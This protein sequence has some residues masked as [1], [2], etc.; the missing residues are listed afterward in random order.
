MVAAA[1]QHVKTQQI[2]HIICHQFAQ[3]KPQKTQKRRESRFKFIRGSPPHFDQAF[4][5]GVG[6]PRSLIVSF[7]RG[8]CPIRFLITTENNVFTG[9][10][11][12]RRIK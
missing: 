2:P 8:F 6:L 7:A 3:T 1:L 5:Y 12:T 9:R 10:C 4:Q 11:V